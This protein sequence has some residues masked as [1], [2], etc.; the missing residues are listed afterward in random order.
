MKK[1]FFVCLG[2][3]FLTGVILSCNSDKNLRLKS[4]DGRIEA[5]LTSGNEDDPGLRFSVFYDNVQILQDCPFT[6]AFKGMRGMGR[7][8]RVS[9]SNEKII[10]E[11]WE[12]GMG[13]EQTGH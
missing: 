9:G 11:S 4:P 3:I 1:I 6:L 10:D 5:L 13:Q 8:L 2:Y 12:T 7:N